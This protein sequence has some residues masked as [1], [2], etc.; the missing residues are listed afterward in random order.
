MRDEALAAAAAVDGR[1]VTGPQAGVPVALKDVFATRGVRTTAGSEALVDAVPEADDTVVARLRAAGAV[2]VGKT[3]MNELGWG[4][5]PRFGRVNNPCDPTRTAGGS[6]GGSAAAVG[7]GS[8]PLAMGT[9]SGGSVRL[10]AHYCGVVGLK[11][12]WGR[13]PHRGAG[14]LGAAGPLARTVDDAAALFAVVAD[15]PG[16]VTVRDRPPRLGLLAGALDGLEAPVE[17]ALR[18]A[19][20]RLAVAESVEVD[21]IEAWEPAWMATF[22]PECAAAQGPALQGSRHLLSRDVRVLHELGSRVPAPAYVRAQQARTLLHAAVERALEG[23]DAL[24][25]A[26]ADHVAPVAEPGWED[27]G[28]VGGMRFQ[29]PFNLTGHPAI[30]LPIPGP[31]LPV[32]LQLVGRRGA[33]EDL[34]SL[35]AWVEGALA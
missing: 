29:A 10:P 6:S 1:R 5:S 18:R 28:W 27:E 13:V 16:P 4:L 14:S 3:N 2:I 22:M 7:S 30:S 8:V 35:A 19:L 32:G 34:L 26:A 12:G 23:V 21:G 24:V 9:D 11:P 20:E 31:G 25:T 15:T 33:D 17:E